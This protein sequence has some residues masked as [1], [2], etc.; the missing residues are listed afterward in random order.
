MLNDQYPNVLDLA[1]RGQ[2]LPN[3]PYPREGTERRSND[4]ALLPLERGGREGIGCS[5]RNASLRD[6]ASPLLRMRAVSL[7]IILR[8]ASR[9]MPAGILDFN[10]AHRSRRWGRP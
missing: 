7:L 1:Q 9:R 5:R 3:P 4:G 10:T 2:S 8:G 6:A